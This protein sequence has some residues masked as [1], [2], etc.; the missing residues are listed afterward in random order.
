MKSIAQSMNPHD[1]AQAF[2]GQDDIAFS[3][4]VA[5]L[6]ASDPRLV[7]VFNRTRKRYLEEKKPQSDAQG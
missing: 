7:D 2:F 3:E 6:A 1:A 4:M 5:K